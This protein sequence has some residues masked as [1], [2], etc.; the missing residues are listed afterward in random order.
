MGDLGSALLN[1]LLELPTADRVGDIPAH[2][3]Y[4]H[5]KQHK[6]GSKSL[7]RI[8]NFLGRVERDIA[9]TIKGSEAP[10]YLLPP[11]F[12]S[13]NACA[14][15]AKIHAARRSTACAPQVECIGKVKAYKTYEFGVEVSMAT[16]LHS[17]A[18]ETLRQAVETL[19]PQPENDDDAGGR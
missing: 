14:S 1:H 5:A 3:H 2:E 15:S 10:R 9:R 16:T 4:K 18:S 8:R 7:C 13:P 11:H 17:C 6:Q 19:T 12:I